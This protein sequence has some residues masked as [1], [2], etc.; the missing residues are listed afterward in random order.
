MQERKRLE[1]IRQR[2]QKEIQQAMEFELKVSPCLNPALPPVVPRC[3]LHA[4]GAVPPWLAR[5]L[6]C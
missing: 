4:A 6:P 1:R 5:S 3:M 2:Q